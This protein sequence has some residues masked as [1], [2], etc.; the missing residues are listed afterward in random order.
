MCFNVIFNEIVSDWK[1]ELYSYVKKNAL[2][3][4][5]KALDELFQTT[6]FYCRRPPL[7]KGHFIYVAF[8]FFRNHEHF[9]GSPLSDTMLTKKNSCLLLTTFLVAIMFIAFLELTSMSRTACQNDRRQSQVLK[10]NVIR[11]QPGTS[12]NYKNYEYSESKSTLKSAGGNEWN[13]PHLGENSTRA[14]DPHNYKFLTVKDIRRFEAYQF[15]PGERTLMELTEN[16]HL[17]KCSNVDEIRIGKLLGHGKYK[18][19]YIGTFRNRKVAVKVVTR[20]Y[21]SGNI[22][23]RL[24]LN[25]LKKASL[26]QVK[27]TMLFKR[28]KQNSPVDSMVYEIINHAVLDYPNIVRHLGYCVRDYVSNTTKNGILAQGIISVFEFGDPF[29]INSLSNLPWL[30]KVAHCREIANLLELTEH[31]LVG[32]VSY[33]DMHERHFMMV[34]GRIKLIDLDTYV[35]PVETKCGLISEIPVRERMKKRKRQ[36][37]SHDCSSSWV[38]ASCVNGTCQGLNAKEN[39]YTFTRIFFSKMLEYDKIPPAILE[40]ITPF[41]EDVNNMKLNATALREGFDSLLTGNLTFYA[42]TWG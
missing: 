35:T 24:I 37:Y 21:G 40:H 32:S 30:E 39:I 13:L 4:H 3:R 15:L 14:N 12:T 28:C 26:R 18:S 36:R 22:C 20:R 11:R 31:S 27:E 16:R 8:S 33:T 5:S 38:N 17:I 19:T 10:H 9:K 23:A 7:I 42:E 1:W 25:S 41:L 29:C 6:F 34:N 2:H